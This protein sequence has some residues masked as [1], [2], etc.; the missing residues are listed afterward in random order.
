MSELVI[1]TAGE[2]LNE[3]AVVAP[4]GEEDVE[5]GSPAGE[6]PED[7]VEGPHTPEVVEHELRR[8]LVHV[9]S[10]TGACESRK[11]QYQSFSPEKCD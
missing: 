9:A 10:P 5:E 11:S 6:V 8:L 4:E 2:N 1:R 3:E 7:H